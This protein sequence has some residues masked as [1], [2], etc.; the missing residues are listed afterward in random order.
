MRCYCCDKSLNDFES[1]LRHAEHNYFLDMCRK[2]IDE[3]QVPFVGRPD[4]NPFDEI[5]D[6]DFPITNIL[7]EDDEV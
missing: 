4:L 7:E 6:D 5:V 2:C 3:T 1:T